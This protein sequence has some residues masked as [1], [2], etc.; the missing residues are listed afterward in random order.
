[1]GRTIHDLV[2]MITA[3]TA[4]L[5]MD[6]SPK[7]VAFIVSL[8][9]EGMADIENPSPVDGWLTTMADELNR[10]KDEAAR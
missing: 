8:F 7:D 9:F 6:L 2:D 5:G 4:E 3:C 1:M 10:V